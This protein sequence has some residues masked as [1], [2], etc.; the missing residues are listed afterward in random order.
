MPCNFTSV[1]KSNQSQSK[2]KK[3]NRNNGHEKMT[4]NYISFETKTG[5]HVSDS[6]IQELIQ[7]EAICLY[8]EIPN[9]KNTPAIATVTTSRPVYRITAAENSEIAEFGDDEFRIICDEKTKMELIGYMDTIWL[10]EPEIHWLTKQRTPIR[11][12]FRSI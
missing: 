6:A 7:G 8:P 4:A 12:Q 11:I 2:F 10:D 1:F 3:M 5:Y 9:T